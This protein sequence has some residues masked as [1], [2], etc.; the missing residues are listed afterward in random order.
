MIPEG[1]NTFLLKAQQP[2]KE[3]WVGMDLE[4]LIQIKSQDLENILDHVWL[5]D[6][7]K[8]RLITKGKRPH[9]FTCDEIIHLQAVKRYGDS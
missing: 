9:C 5:K 7:M 6:G 1:S 2:Q 4:M 8:L 3:D